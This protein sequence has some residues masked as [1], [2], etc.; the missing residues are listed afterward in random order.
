MVSVVD[1][2]APRVLQCTTNLVSP[3]HFLLYSD[4]MCD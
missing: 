1:G 3:I 2:A 4:D